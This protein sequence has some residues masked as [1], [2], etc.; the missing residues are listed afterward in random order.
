MNTTKLR[1]NVED[2]SVESFTPAEESMGRG[3]V[4][5]AETAVED[6]CG[7]TLCGAASQDW[8][9]CP[10]LSC[11]PGDCGGNPETYAQHTCAVNCHKDPGVE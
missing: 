4:H 7:G 5:G 9:H 1:L 2:L 3:T 8:T 10:N 6:S 11:L